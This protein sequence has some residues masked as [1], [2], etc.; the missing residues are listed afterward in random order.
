M[1]DRQYSVYMHIFPD[2]RRYIGAT[3]QIPKQ[4]WRNG[5]GYR[6]QSKFFAE[7]E[8]VGWENIKHIIVKSELSEN[9]AMELE[10]NLIAK[11]NTQDILFGFNTKN[12]G[13]CFGEHSEKFLRDLK[14]RMKGN[15]YCIDRKLS[16][17]HLEAL[18]NSNLGSHRPSKHKGECFLSDES[19]KLI[20]DK[21]VE[22]WK[23][24]EYKEK[25]KK[26]RRSM[27]GENNP[28]YGK[29]HSKETKE[30]IRIKAT[31]RIPGEAARIKMSKSCS[32]KKA[33]YRLNIQ[34]DID[35][36]FESCKAAAISVDGNASN[37]GFACR[38]PDRTY[39]GYKWRYVD[40]F[41][42]G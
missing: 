26:I 35:K 4:R 30:K 22:R 1:G 10:K 33:V 40:G 25:M 3:R 19:K 15:K 32:G 2:G 41:D 6:N 20:S 11:Y 16:P 7:I 21:A 39:K 8:K 18:R 42:R 28:M 13:Q 5:R 23:N 9:D 36:M 12:G 31:G 37:I 29:K 24:P 38:N 17:S 14:A 34:G 27:E